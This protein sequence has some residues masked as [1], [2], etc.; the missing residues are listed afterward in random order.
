MLRKKKEGQ[1]LNKIGMNDGCV[2]GPPR[3][4][5]VDGVRDI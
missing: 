3:L 4:R 2:D 1:Q 5:F